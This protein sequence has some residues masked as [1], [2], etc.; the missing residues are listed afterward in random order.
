MQLYQIPATFTVEL[1]ILALDEI[2]TETVNN[3]APYMPSTTLQLKYYIHK[4]SEEQH[5]V[6]HTLPLITSAS[7]VKSSS[8]T[9]EPQ[10]LLREHD[11]VVD[12]LP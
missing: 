3:T 4:R 8:L 9:L 12:T 5:T 1:H 7:A 6:V 2:S 10:F 11:N